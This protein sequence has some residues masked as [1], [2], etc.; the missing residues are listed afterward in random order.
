MASCMCCNTP[1]TTGFVVCGSCAEQ[2]K[3]GKLSLESMRLIGKLAEAISE[4]ESIYP[5]TMCAYECHGQED[6]HVC[7]DGIKAWLTDKAERSASK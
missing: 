7:P 5:C 1:I 6:A 3:S 4:D 2:V